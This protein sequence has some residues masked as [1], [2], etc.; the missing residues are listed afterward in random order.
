MTLMLNDPAQPAGNAVAPPAGSAVAPPAGS[1]VAPPAPVRRE[2]A[3][4]LPAAATTQIAGSHRDPVIDLIRFGCLLV[5]VVLHALMS[6]A[7]LGPDG[8]VVPTVALSD[9][10]G[11]AAAS[12][13]F[14]IMPLFFIIGGYAGITGWRRMRAQGGTWADYL[15]ARLRRLIVPTAVLIVIAGIGLSAAADM[16]VPSD[17]IVEASRR[18]GQPLWFLAVYLGLS[19]LVPV[20]VHFHERAPR[21]S[22]AVL[23]GAVIV[24]D[25]LTAVTGLLGLGYL[26]FVFVWPL[27]Q[28]LGFFFADHLDRPVHR[29][30]VWS[31]LVAALLLLG[32]LVAAGVFSPNMLVNL[33]PPTG[34]L[35]LLGV[36]QLCVLRLLY[37]RLNR[38]LS[39]AQRASGSETNTGI[40][41]TEATPTFG[42]VPV[43]FWGRVIAW[44]NAFGMQVY[45]WHMSVVIV[46]IGAL[47]WLAH[48]VASFPTGIL[49][50][51][52]I[53]PVAEFIL[54]EVESEW[55]WAT[56]LPWLLAVMG[57]S[58]LVA[59]ATRRIPFPSE[60]QLAA[61][62]R[63]LMRPVR[64][65][66]TRTTLRVRALRPQARAAAAIGAATCGIA[67]ALLVGVAPMIWTVVAAGLLVGSLILSAGID[68][69]SDHALTRDADPGSDNAP[70][71]DDEPIPGLGL[72]P[73]A[74]RA[75]R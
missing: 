13:L 66:S 9:T 12:W 4:A 20:A 55:W 27:I 51:L 2:S 34:A 56:R 45:L 19:S 15:R 73:R 54:P 67:V 44:G 32:G 5:V 46:L 61:A 52:P 7:V 69:D 29:S 25:V 10:P 26:N 11:F 58:A 72:T 49:L 3:P 50:D 70:A 14:Q 59:M 18:I 43:Q 64:A 30:K 31:V 40:T 39:P 42:V 28:Q 74:E 65:L 41:L 33:N 17:L 1:A 24:V 57:F 71:R 21:R 63:R 68:L 47:G 23:A 53:G 36:A 48:T 37:A 22:L 6:A 16:G 60:R 62:D 38:A 35:V 75:D 8:A